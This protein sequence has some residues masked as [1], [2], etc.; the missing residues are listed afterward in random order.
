MKKILTIPVALTTLFFLTTI[1]SCVKNEFDA[2]TTTNVDPDLVVSK[3]ISELQAMAAGTTPVLIS[4][5][6]VIAGVVI[7]DDLSGN[8]YKEIIIQDSTAAIAIQIDQSNFNT[9]YPIGRRIFVKCNG[10]V[11]ADDGD[12]NFQLGIRDLQT[13]GRIPSGLVP[14]Y[15]VAGKW[16]IPV[17]PKTVSMANIS[18]EPTQTLIR[19]ENVEFSTA[20]TSL[21]YANAATQQSQNRII[22]D[23]N[24]NQADLY[25][26]GYANFAGAI[27]P[28]GKGTLVAVYKQYAGSPELEIRNTEDV[29]MSG[30]RC[31]GGTG[32]S[33]GTGALMSIADVRAAYTGGSA[34]F[35][36]GTKIRGVVISDLTTANITSNNLI[37]Q[38][39]VAGIIVRFTT[40]NTFNL[41]DSLEIDLSSDSLQTYQ[42]G[43]E[44]N[45]VSSSAVTVLGTGTITPNTKTTSFISTNLST[46]ESTLIKVTGATL[47]GG[48][49]G[50]YSGTVTITDATGT[51]LLYTR[52]GATFSGTSYPTG[53][54][55]VTGFLSN[56]NGTP[57]LIIRGTGDVQ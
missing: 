39:G 49:S 55:S 48:T 18:N 29:N 2:P 33:V 41:N 5:N 46:L 37:L 50:T 1:S 24:G 27:T 4:T 35:V 36:A 23:C 22:E 10:L 26:S 51:L 12:G 45:Y 8:F 54:V 38:D 20:D 30:P 32:V 43:Q 14:R 47:T 3:S 44:V 11:I 40:P 28:S 53:T 21:P 7:A 42:Q 17:T 6:E 13:V 56:Y 52:G 19:L 57:E 25:S 16:G 34:V 15:I 9:L 31:G